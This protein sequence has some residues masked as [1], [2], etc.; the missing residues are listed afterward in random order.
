M[1]S[2]D[3]TCIPGLWSIQ[4]PMEV[5]KYTNAHCMNKNL[6][7]LHHYIHITEHLISNLWAIRCRYNYFYFSGK[8]FHK[9]VQQDCNRDFLPF[10]KGALVRSETGMTWCSCIIKFIQKVLD[11]DKVPCLQ[12][13]VVKNAHDIFFPWL[14]ADNQNM[15][16]LLLYATKSSTKYSY[17][18]SYS[19]KI[20]GVIALRKT[21]ILTLLSK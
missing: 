20:F 10:N 15:F 3:E 12:N 8:T 16:H 7:T 21:E 5:N 19:Q 13:D 6:Q 11:E 1:Y 4:Q 9:T 18:R 14:K 2:T 17:M